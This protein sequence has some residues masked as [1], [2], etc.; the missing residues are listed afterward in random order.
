MNCKNC[1]NTLEQDAK[2]CADCG[3]KVIDHRITMGHL[4]TE[5]KEGFFSIDSSKPIR[6]Y[7]HMFTKPEEVIGGY[8]NGVRKKYINA[9]SYLTIA[10]TFSSFFFFIF[11]KW[12]PDALNFGSNIDTANLQNKQAN[13]LKVK[14]NSILFEY[15]SIL[16]FAT[17][18]LLAII[19]RIT[20]LKNKLYNYAEH[21]IITLYTYS[22]SSISAITLY[23]LMVWNDTIFF[24]VATISLPLQ[25]IYY[26]YVLKKLYRL[27]V[28]QIILKTLLFML[29][30]AVFFFIIVIIVS[31]C[32]FASGAFDNLIE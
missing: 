19:C 30:F 20:F 14:W 9:F 1:K 11:L 32:L 8:I 24:V 5:M 15:S 27:S 7:L 22:H 16:V 18:P 26:A 17:I 28:S 4:A 13:D 23:L 3:A 12:F 31:L 6:T 10:L 25:T 29:I 21:L 2:F